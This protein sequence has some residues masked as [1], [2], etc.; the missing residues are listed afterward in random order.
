MAF[1]SAAPSIEVSFVTTAA[2]IALCNIAE[3]GFT[4]A[5]ISRAVRISPPVPRH[6]YRTSARMRGI[7]VNWGFYGLVD[8]MSG[9]RPISGL[10][11]TPQIYSTVSELI[12]R[13]W[14]L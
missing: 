8:T 14:L 6:D 9:D 5:G 7:D 2:P 13:S 3:N 11:H 4:N 10:H 12:P 1:L